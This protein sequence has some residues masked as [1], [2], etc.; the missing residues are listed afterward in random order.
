MKKSTKIICIIS[1]LL[2]ELAALYLTG[3]I[4]LPGMGLQYRFWVS[5]IGK[6]LLMIV[7]PLWLIGLVFWKLFRIYKANTKK[8]G[9]VRFFSAIAAVLY[10]CWCWLAFIFIVFTTPEDIYLGGGLLSV[11]VESFPKPTSY[12]L[13]EIVGPFFRRDSSL[14]H[15]T[16]IRF[17]ADKYK[18]DFYP[19]EGDGAILCAD[20]ERPNVTVEIRFINGRIQ[21]DYPQA[22]ADYYLQEGWNTLELNWKYKFTETQDNTDRMRFCLI[23]TE[24]KDCA[25]FAEDAYQLVQY[26][27]K[28]DSLLE[29]YDVRLFYSSAEYE[30]EYG[31]LRFGRYKTWESLSYQLNGTDVAKITQYLILEYSSMRI[32]AAEN[33]RQEAQG[34]DPNA[35]AF[36][37]TVQPTPE[38]TPQPTPQKTDREIAEETYPEQCKAAEAIWNT[39]LKDLGYD[40]EPDL[41]NR[42]NLVIWLGKLPSENLQNTESESN[43]YLTY[44]RESKNGNC[45]LFVLSEVPEGKGLNDAYLREFYACEKATLKVVAGN[46]TSWGQPGCEAYR[47]ITGE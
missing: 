37:E 47:E 5:S 27:L 33:A 29:N 39:E 16:A 34:S 26:A 13:Y 20:M 17:L 19:V 8:G 3:V 32:R 25:A 10:L 40:Y 41:N 7:I 38:L 1:C 30:D 14:T 22:L 42:G 43:Y 6:I 18:R 4:V 11:V 45:Y 46:K 12:D 44:D 2:F 28:Q 9:I 23:L 24:E 35:S 15:E 36:P 21:D 31:Y